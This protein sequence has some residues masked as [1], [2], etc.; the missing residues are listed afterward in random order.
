MDRKLLGIGL[1]VLFFSFLTLGCLEESVEL[2]IEVSRTPHERT[3]IDE[4]EPHLKLAVSKGERIMKDASLGNNGLSC[5][6]CHPNPEINSDWAQ[7]FP[8]RWAS[9]RNPEHRI[10]T[11]AQHNYGAHIDMMEGNLTSEDPAFLYLNTYLIWLGDG[12]EV[13][14]IEKP[15]KNQ[16]DESITRGEGLFHDRN[17]G[18]SGKSCGSCHTRESLVGAAATFPKYSRVYDQVVLMDSFIKMHAAR[19]QGWDMDLMSQELTDL[20]TFL[21]N[22]SKDYIISLER[23]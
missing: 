13:W 10:I 11:L 5:D 22:L 9:T 16:L 2:N 18:D 4:L 19:N 15:G 3:P 8:R 21:T 1:L 17:V 20:S 14:G 6:S 23:T 12:K 7:I